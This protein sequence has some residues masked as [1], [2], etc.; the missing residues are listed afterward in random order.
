MEFFVEWSPFFDRGD[1][2]PFVSV[3]KPSSSDSR[4]D[5]DVG[6]EREPKDILLHCIKEML[7][8]SS[9]CVR[10]LMTLVASAMSVS[11]HI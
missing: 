6:R 7:S 1:N 2:Q 3:E 8:Y 10:S 11:F 5:S 9:S 4:I